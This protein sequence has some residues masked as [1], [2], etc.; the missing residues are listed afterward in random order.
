[1][2]ASKSSRPAICSTRYETPAN[3]PALCPLLVLA[4][5]QQPSG[6]YSDSFR[7]SIRTSTAAIASSASVALVTESGSGSPAAV[8]ANLPI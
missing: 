1:M 5:F 7:V 2:L 4:R 6:A 3:Y 8:A